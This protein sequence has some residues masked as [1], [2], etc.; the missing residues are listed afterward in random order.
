LSN[1]L[2]VAFDSVRSSARDAAL[3]LPADERA[4]S[5]G[6]AFAYSVDLSGLNVAVVGDVTTAGATVT[7]FARTLRAAGAMRVE[8]WVVASTPPPMR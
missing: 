5:I 7:E 6:G 2:S 4:A 3:A 1:F 8:H